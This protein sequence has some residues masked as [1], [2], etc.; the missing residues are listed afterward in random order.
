ML[1]GWACCLD[2]WRS[3]LLNSAMAKICK[4]ALSSARFP[5][6]IFMEFMLPRVFGWPDIFDV[7]E[8]ELLQLR[9]LT[10]FCRTL[11]TYIIHNDYISC[12][13]K[14][15]WNWIARIL[16][17]IIREIGGNMCGR[18]FCYGFCGFHYFPILCL[19]KA[20]KKDRNHLKRLKTKTGL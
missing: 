13:V 16:E 15:T 6:A 11:F 2:A 4:K 3:E 20:F 8:L 1:S 19:K 12:R 9:G 14:H 5:T 10:I 18:I 7:T 17:S